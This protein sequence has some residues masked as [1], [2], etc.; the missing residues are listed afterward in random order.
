MVQ[1]KVIL[2]VIY[3]LSL[4][5]S[6]YVVI[7]YF[8]F[9]PDQAAMVAAKLSDRSFP[10]TIWLYFFYPHIILGILALICGGFQLT[11]FSQRRRKQHRFFGRI[12]AYSVFLNSLIVPYLALFATGGLPST[13]AFLFLDLFWLVTTGLAILHIRNKKIAAHRRWM[14]RSY[15][16]TFVFVTFR[17]LLVILQLLSHAPF[18][19]TFPLSIVLAL[20][21]NLAAAQIY[22]NKASWKQQ[23]S[24]RLEG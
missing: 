19:I 7:Q 24:K 5:L 8:V 11:H 15:A 13:L 21:L 3:A 4:L 9:R 20:L 6:V 1:R 17:V 16:V 12:Y 10:Y 18:S 2:P 23:P 14:I 22:L